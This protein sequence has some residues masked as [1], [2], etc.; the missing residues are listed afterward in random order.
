MCMIVC[1]SVVLLTIVAG[2]IVLEKS[3][4]L[5]GTLKKTG[6]IIGWVVIV[7]STLM[8]L[9]SLCCAVACRGKMMCGGNMMGKH[10]MY[11]KGM[12]MQGQMRGEM[13][14]K[15]KGMMDKEEQEEMEKSP[16]KMEK[17]TK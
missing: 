2:F 9:C 16:G 14:E 6:S 1:I 13:R 10:M 4:K 11:G 7:I 5:D 8:L 3:S 12:C 15:M 17:G